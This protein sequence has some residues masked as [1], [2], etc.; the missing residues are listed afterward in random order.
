[1]AS[2]CIE[3][4][5]SDQPN[6][7]DDVDV[8]LTVD[9]LRARVVSWGAGDGPPEREHGA[10]FASADGATLFVYGGSGYPQ[11]PDNVLDDGWRFDV[12]T[13]TWTTWATSGERPPA[14]A[15]RG[16]RVNDD[17]AVLVGGYLADFASDGGAY[18]VTLSTGVFRALRQEPQPPA[19]SLHTLAFDDV[20]GRLVLFG[21]F[22]DDGPRNDAW[23]GIV[24]VDDGVITWTEV[25]SSEKPSPRYGAFGGVDT[26]S[27]Q[28][29]VFSGA[30]APRG[31]DA[32]NAAQDIWTL[33]LDDATWS[34]RAVFGAPPNGRRNGCGVFDPATRALII[35]GGT[36]DGRT[37]EAG[38]AALV[39]EGDDGDV[40]RFVD[41]DVGDAPVRSSGFGAPLVGGGVA[42]GFGNDS[43][44]FRDVIMWEPSSLSRP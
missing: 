24:N 2:A 5:V 25:G 23:I 20:A 38:G 36:A 29:V 22:G 35:Y 18:A 41:V 40:L 15:F 26:Q 27:G 34:E 33:N 4:A 1:M 28:L 13:A 39:V 12:Q 6:D 9:A 30:Q 21:G 16:V 44:A 8:P 17:T 43:D 11:T 32:I 37:S 14:G 31:A 19:R 3:P 10:M 42:C 7:D